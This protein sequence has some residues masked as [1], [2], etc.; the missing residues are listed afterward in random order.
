MELTEQEIIRG[1]EQIPEQA[2]Q[3]TRQ[4]YQRAVASGHPVTVVIGD[5]IVRVQTTDEG[6]RQESTHRTV[7]TRRIQARHFR[8]A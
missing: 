1:E 2:G 7:R 6:I 4:A 3:A 8:I 5:E